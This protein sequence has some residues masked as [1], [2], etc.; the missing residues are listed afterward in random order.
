MVST[1]GLHLQLRFT[2]D[3]VELQGRVHRMYCYLD[4]DISLRILGHMDQLTW[5]DMD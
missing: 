4:P 2:P 3:R 5:C 1:S